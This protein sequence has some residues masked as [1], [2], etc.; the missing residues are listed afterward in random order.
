MVCK[1]SPISSRCPG[2][3]KPWKAAR[4]G[5]SCAER[6]LAV[7]AARGLALLFPCRCRGPQGPPRAETSTTT[8]CLKADAL[9]RRLHSV[10]SVAIVGPHRR[11]LCDIGPL[12]STRQEQATS[13]LSLLLV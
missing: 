13:V 10:E 12:S 3:R 2:L 11:L 8:E 9:R 7:S 4:P 5:L 1:V 6:S